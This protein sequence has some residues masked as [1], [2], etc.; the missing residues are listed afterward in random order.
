V[1]VLVTRPPEDAEPLVRDLRARGHT[2]VLSPLLHIRVDAAARVD[3][4]GVQAVLFTSANGVRAFA[5]ACACRDVA[6]LAVGPSTAETA[7][8]AGF[9]EIETAGGDS[10][11]LADLAVRTRDPAAGALFHAA[12]SVTAGDLKGRL[13][14]A[15]FAVH[16]QTLYTAEPAESLSSAAVAALHAG[17]VDAALFYSPRTAATFVRLARTANLTDPC[18]RVSA[19]CLSPAVANAVSA[20]SWRDV[21]TA[22]RPDRAA[23]LRTLDDMAGP[24]APAPGEA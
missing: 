18:G 8:A 3:L 19:V 20:L 15:G 6:V 16:R 14:A 17:E 5:Q 23:L 13:E 11:A 1:K 4:T 24:S 21:R 9:A 22:E 10:G 2:A 12:G 7:R